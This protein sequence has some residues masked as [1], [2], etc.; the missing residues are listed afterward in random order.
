MMEFLKNMFKR[1]KSTGIPA[2]AS[3][4]EDSTVLHGEDP[5][6]IPPEDMA[7][8]LTDEVKE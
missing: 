1:N 2:T 3:V 7:N 5:G 8:P 4:I 6:V